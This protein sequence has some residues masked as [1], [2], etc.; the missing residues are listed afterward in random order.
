MERVAR[1]PANVRYYSKRQKSGRKRS[2]MQIVALR[3]ADFSTLFRSRYGI[4]LPD[5]DSGRDDI[6]LVVDHLASLAHP[7][8]AITKWLETWAPWMTLAEHRE[9][10]AAGIAN[11]RNWKADALAWRLGLTY[12]ERSMLGIT[13]IGAI[14]MSRAQ[15]EKRRKEKDRARQAAKRRAAG[16]VPRERYERASVEKSK[17]WLAEGISRRTWYRRLASRS[18]AD[19][20]D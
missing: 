19:P 8:R 7:A 15:R 10:I 20:A 11:Q 17:P 5:D 18:G 9:T 2:P 13:T 4:M 3:V 6:R 1:R 12:Q 14:D 16:V